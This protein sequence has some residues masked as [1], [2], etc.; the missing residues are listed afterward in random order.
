M[1][2]LLLD[3]NALIH[4]LESLTTTPTYFPIRLAAKPTIS[5]YSCR[6]REWTPTLI[7]SLL[8]IKYTHS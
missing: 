5:R 4:V 8:E 6:F 7:I 2:G 3:L 1:L